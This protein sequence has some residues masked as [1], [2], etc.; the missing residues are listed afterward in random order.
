[1]DSYNLSEALQS[2]AIECST[3]AIMQRTL[4]LRLCDALKHERRRVALP[5]LASD[6]LFGHLLDQL[7]TAAHNA[8][9]GAHAATIRAHGPDELIDEDEYQPRTASSPPLGL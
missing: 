9:A 1:M 7:H 5:K 4:L 2:L 3:D 6:P 8:A